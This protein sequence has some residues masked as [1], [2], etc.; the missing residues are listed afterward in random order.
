MPTEA[1]EAEKNA[2]TARLYRFSGK[3]TFDSAV[4]TSS[5]TMLVP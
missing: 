4:L 2:F 1:N 3:L 5:G